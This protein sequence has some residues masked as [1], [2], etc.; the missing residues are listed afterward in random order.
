MQTKFFTITVLVFLALALGL[1]I[2]LDSFNGAINEATGLAVSSESFPTYLETHPAVSNLP[3]DALIGVKIGATSYEIEG[4]EVSK[5]QDSLEGD[6]VVTLPE[7]YEEVIGELGLCKA[8]R[9][10]YLEDKI[11]VE[12]SLNKMSLF[13]KYRKLLK[14]GDCLK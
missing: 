7:G 8:I 10:A 2:L 13:L 12:T 11:S 1:F 6:V 14:Y 9:K 3:K 4:R 5:I